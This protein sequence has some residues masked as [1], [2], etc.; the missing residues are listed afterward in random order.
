MTLDVSQ[1]A[2][3]RRFAKALDL[4]LY[5]RELDR[6]QI[7][8]PLVVDADVAIDVIVG[9]TDWDPAV[10]APR[11]EGWSYVVQALI[12]TGYVPPLR[13]LRPHLVELDRFISRI[14]KPTYGDTDLRKAS[15]KLLADQW[16]LSEHDSVLANR[17][18][19][20][21]ALDEFV[22]TEGF[23][24]F[25]KLELCYGGTAYD[26]FLRI[27]RHL[28]ISNL[29]ASS[30]VHPGD[31]L[32][33]T[34]TE[35]VASARSQD[36]KPINDTVDGYALAEL[37]RMVSFGWPVRFFTQTGALLNLADQPEFRDASGR[38]VFRNLDYFVMR[39]SFS[40]LRFSNMVALTRKQGRMVGKSTS[41][42]HFMRIRD[43]LQE[44]LNRE[45]NSGHGLSPGEFERALERPEFKEL[46]IIETI[47]NFKKLEF[48]GEV[49]LRW[50]LP[51]PME[52]FIPYLKA[53]FDQPTLI[54]ETR[55]ELSQSHSEVSAA[56]DETVGNLRNWK[57]DYFEIR[58]AM[59]VVREEWEQEP[60]PWR[61]L[62]LG[63]WGLA[64]RSLF[65]CE[66]TS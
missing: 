52:Y 13:F 28:D 36:P 33:K 44:I 53:K 55:L 62:G 10:E 47:D 15:L 51:K 9:L 65:E 17:P 60:D 5:D 29:S 48:L 56:L 4:A 37:A 61:D 59:R 23:E 39:C 8:V 38:T 32:A 24:V 11:V 66:E 35:L 41:L 49:F 26:R 42:K 43:A 64:G 50:K 27:C 19:T 3:V 34:L 30:G 45:E 1:L 46:K 2:L 31:D 22:R 40:A 16:Q 25:V 57:N 7:K 63:R 54:E 58:T 20:A 18:D 21:A 14:P 6:Q 12:S